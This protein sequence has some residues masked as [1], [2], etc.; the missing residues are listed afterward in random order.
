MSVDLSAAEDD[1]CRL[2]R[3]SE[4][5]RQRPQ[6]RSAAP[7]ARLMQQRL[8]C[9]RRVDAREE[10]RR[11]LRRI[12]GE[13]VRRLPADAVQG[14]DGRVGGVVREIE[15]HRGKPA[16]RSPS[17]EPRK[18]H[19]QR[20]PF[21][22][23]PCATQM[24]PQMVEKVAVVRAGRPPA[25]RLTCEGGEPAGMQRRL[26]RDPG[27]K[28]IAL[29]VVNRVALVVVDAQ[30]RP[31]DEIVEDARDL[32][33]VHALLRPPRPDHGRGRGGM[34][35]KRDEVDVAAPQLIV[36]LLE[37]DQHRPAERFVRI[38]GQ[39]LTDLGQ[40]HGAEA[41]QRV[42][43]AIRLAPNRRRDHREGDGEPAARVRD[44]RRVRREIRAC[45]VRRRRQQIERLVARQLVDLDFVYARA[46]EHV[47][48]PAG[49]QDANVLARRRMQRLRHIGR[50]DDWR[51]ATAA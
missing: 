6:P 10:L 19:E 44:R 4:G 49:Q 1:H 22:L 8:E 20:T 16:D 47:P 27:R 12:V 28:E 36:E 37:A 50:T 9:R 11:Q 38:V 17:G 40:I 48:L 14:S 45:H 26:V 32:Q 5:R 15:Q 46:G 41:G 3:V 25:R 23:S 29:N 7:R 35:W 13:D 21:A 24:V 34:P 2:A 18:G 51:L 33:F 31:V 42:A 43:P 39:P 30:Q